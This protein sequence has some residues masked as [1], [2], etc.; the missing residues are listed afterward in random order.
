M[1]IWFSCFLSGVQ[2]KHK[3][4]FII[5]PTRHLMPWHHRLHQRSRPC[6]KWIQSWECVRS[7]LVS[8][9]QQADIKDTNH[10]D[11]TLLAF[12]LLLIAGHMSSLESS[13]I[14]C[15]LFGIKGNQRTFLWFLTPPYIFPFILYQNLTACGLETIIMYSVYITVCY[16]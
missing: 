1:N 16:I 6:G 10:K 14:R 15:S 4:T 12:G 13:L 5:R 3:Y 7:V 9:C 8:L 11:E 2:T